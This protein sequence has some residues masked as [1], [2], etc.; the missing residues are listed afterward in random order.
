MLVD[1]SDLTLSYFAK[2]FKQDMQK[3][4]SAYYTIIRTIRK[5]NY[6]ENDSERL[7]IEDKLEKH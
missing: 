7:S 2:W 6:K 3:W 1:T 4:N 5:P